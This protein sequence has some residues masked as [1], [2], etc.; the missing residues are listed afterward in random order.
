M[1]AFRLIFSPAALCVVLGWATFA[2]REAP[3]SDDAPGASGRSDRHGD[4]LPTGAFARLGTIRFR[5]P[6]SGLSHVAVAPNGKLL[7]TAGGTDLILWDAVTGKEVRRLPAHETA[8]TS[9]AFAPDGARLATSTYHDGD[10]LLWDVRTGKRLGALR[11]QCCAFAAAGKLLVTADAGGTPALLIL[12]DAATGARRRRIALSGPVTSLA[13]AA[14]GRRVAL[15]LHEE[16]STLHVCDTATWAEPQRLTSLGGDLM[17]FTFAPNGKSLAAVAGD[18]SL[19]VWNLGT[20]KF[21]R[22]WASSDMARTVAYS[23]DGRLLAWAGDAGPIHLGSADGDERPRDVGEPFA[24]CL[25]FSPDGKRLFDGTRSGAVRVWDVASGRDA[26]PFAAHGDR[27]TSLTF[28]PDSRTVVTTSYDGAIVWDALSGQARRRFPDGGYHGPAVL[29]VSADGRSAVA[30]ADNG[31]LFVAELA[32]GRKTVALEVRNRHRPYAVFSPDGRLVAVDGGAFQ[33][34]LCDARTGKHLRQLGQSSEGD[35]LFPEFSPGGR[36]ILA[37]GLR[38]HNASVYEAATAWQLA[39]FRRK[40]ALGQVAISP[41]DRILAVA[42]SRPHVRLWDLARD[43]ELPALQGRQRHVG[44]VFFSPDGRLVGTRGKDERWQGLVRGRPPWGE[45]DPTHITLWDAAT[46]QRLPHFG[47]QQGPPLLMAFTADGRTL[48]LAGTDGVLRFWEVATGE[49]R[50]RF[51]GLRREGLP[52]DQP[53]G[54][55]LVFAPD[56]RT[57]AVACGTAALLLDVTGRRPDGRWQPARLTPAEWQGCWDALAGGDATKA[58]R[59]VWA[60]AADPGQSVALLRGRLHA[61]TTPDPKE[62]AALIAG[63][64]SD[65]FAVRERSSRALADL[66]EQAVPALRQALQ[67]QPTLEARRR[68]EKLLGQPGGPVRPSELLRA[69]RAVEVLE[70]IGTPEARELLERLARGTPAARLTREA[71]ASLERLPARSAVP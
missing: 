30:A 32:T 65:R 69:L 47:K 33:T 18:G 66:G 20:G 21:R 19:G 5:G 42:G 61:A 67:G 39:P 54:R 45:G 68:I 15:Q 35:S 12:W 16:K 36:F 62:L 53:W 4:P 10:S 26:V 58:H 55:S 1:Q 56:G 11:G 52:T 9:L 41:K 7:A 3:A 25:A 34:V 59:A 71:R 14:D 44:D 43:K 40:Q 8:I 27:L 24:T 46:G 57:L 2:P 22:R 38:E 51:T 28:T 63:L 60:L 6:A 17:C 70:H 13:L 49:E 37:G 29:A 48:A 23:P 31:E 64:G 50:G